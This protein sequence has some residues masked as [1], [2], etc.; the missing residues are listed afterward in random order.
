MCPTGDTAAQPTAVD[1][2][3]ARP[4]KA[5]RARQLPALTLPPQGVREPLR[6]LQLPS[7]SMAAFAARPAPLPLPPPGFTGPGAFGAA[8]GALPA[9]EGP[10]APQEQA[11]HPPSA[12]Q[13]VSPARGGC[14]HLPG[15]HEHWAG[16]QASPGFP[17]WPIV[18]GSHA[19]SLAAWQDLLGGP[20]CG[21]VCGP[22][23][24]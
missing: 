12:S 7:S 23:V 11:A 19:A 16:G 20:L 6:P 18:R 2:R 8:P 21:A 1:G 4:V 5:S 14:A 24:M 22:N 15:P 17:C 13:V 9:G 3:P 10:A